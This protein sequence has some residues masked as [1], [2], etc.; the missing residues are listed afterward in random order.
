MK[1]EDIQ[2]VIQLEKELVEIEKNL[3]KI[4]E[5]F[6]D[7]KRLN[8]PPKI[9]IETHLTLFNLDYL[10]DKDDLTM[11]LIRKKKILEDQKGRVE[12]QIRDL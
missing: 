6:L 4:E 9:R 3:V 1:R 10:F 7:I 8:I 11:L 5:S 2:K 12:K